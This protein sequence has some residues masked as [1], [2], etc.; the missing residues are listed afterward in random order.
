MGKTFAGVDDDLRAFVGAQR[1]FFVATAPLDPT[2][3]VNARPT[4]WIR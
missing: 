1:M 3:D 2:G 4:V